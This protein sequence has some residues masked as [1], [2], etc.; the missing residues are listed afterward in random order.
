MDCRYDTTEGVNY[1]FRSMPKRRD[2]LEIRSDSLCDSNDIGAIIHATFGIVAD[3]NCS[4]P[5]TDDHDILCRTAPTKN[6]KQDIGNRYDE[7]DRLHL[8]EN[9]FVQRCDGRDA[10]VVPISDRE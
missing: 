4:T 7:I 1:G 3:Q 9:L 5:N 6:S 2:N 10:P 8:H